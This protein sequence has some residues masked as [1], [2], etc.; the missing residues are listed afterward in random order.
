[1]LGKTVYHVNKEEKAQ[2]RYI[3]CT[4]L[5]KADHPHKSRKEWKK[6]DFT[7]ILLRKEHA[8][9]QKNSNKWENRTLDVSC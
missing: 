3:P 2:K 5:E 1:M 6:G 8:L 4:M 7:V 9:S